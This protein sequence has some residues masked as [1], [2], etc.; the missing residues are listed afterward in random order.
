MKKIMGIFLAIMLF[1]GTSWA[2]VINS[3]SS[4]TNASVI[5]FNEW[6]VAWVWAG[7]DPIQIGAPNGD[8]ITWNSTNAYGAHG[9][10]VI[11]NGCYGLGGADWNGYWNNNNTGMGGYVG[12]GSLRYGSMFFIFDE[13]VSSVGGFINHLPNVDVDCTISA[14]DA[15]GTVLETYTIFVNTNGVDNEGAFWGISRN[16]ADIYGFMLSNSSSVLDD[17]TYSRN[18]SNPAPVPEPATILLLGTGLVGLF[19]NAK[20]KLL[21]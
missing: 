11:G 9:S 20:R 8:D 16:T 5:D 14:L 2:I 21:K 19:C 12:L 4:I 3:A 1:A 18:E 6:T 7:D 17:L 15:N 10:S 13:E